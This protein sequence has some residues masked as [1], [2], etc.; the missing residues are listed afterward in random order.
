MGGALT[1]NCVTL[2]IVAASN[3]S[4]LL[5]RNAAERKIKKS[6]ALLPRR[7]S[8]LYGTRSGLPVLGSL[9]SVPGGAPRTSMRNF[10]SYGL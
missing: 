6:R 9:I 5:L 10:W 4:H 8:M 3:R 2:A 1:P 7:R